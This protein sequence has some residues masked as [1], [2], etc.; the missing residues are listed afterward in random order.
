MFLY[1]TI[2]F[3]YLAGSSFAAGF[4]ERCL[5]AESS[6]HGSLSHRERGCHRSQYTNAC[7]LDVFFFKYIQCRWSKEPVGISE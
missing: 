4:S 3:V 6:S 7:K 1:F 2:S 5:I